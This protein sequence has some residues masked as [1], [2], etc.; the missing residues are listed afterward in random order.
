M[1]SNQ[2]IC[3]SLFG[4][5][6][7]TLLILPVDGQENIADLK[8]KATKF[9]A[10]GN[11]VE[12][13][14]CLNKLGKLYWDQ[15]QLDNAVANYE[16][17]V[18][19]NT[20]LGN[21]NAQRIIYGYLGM[22]CLEKEDYN[23]AITYFGKSFEMNKKAGKNSEQLS[24]LYNIA[25]A[26][27]MLGKYDESNKNAQTALNKAIELN[28]LESAKS[29]NLL[30]SENYDKMGNS[31]KSAEYFA[32]YNSMVKM[33]QQKQMNQ[34]ESDKQ[35]A[36]S[37]ASQ[38]Q[39]K[40]SQK[41][42]ELK[43]VMDTLGEVKELN[44]EMQL[45]KEIKDLELKEQQAR[46]QLEK[47]INE[48]RLKVLSII[49]GSIFIILVL[50]FIQSHHRKMV[51]KKLQEQNSE[52]EKQKIEI[53][54]QRDLAEKQRLNLTSSI[55]YARRIQSAVIPQP[56][57]LYDHF[58][59]SFI[60]YQPKDIVS[61]DFYWFLQKDNIF[62]IAVADCTGHG[63][64]GAF[65]SMLG[66]AYLNEIVN[67][68]AINIHIN[69]LNADEILNQLREKVITS[70]HQSNDATTRDGMDIALCIIDVESK[71]LQFAGANNPLIIVRKGE[72]MQLKAD[73]MPVSYHQRKDI[74]FTRQEIE[75]HNNDCLYLYSDGFQDQPGGIENR[76]YLSSK[77]IQFL[78]NNHQKQMSEQKRLLESEFET[79]RGNNHQI[80]DVLVVGFR[81]GKVTEALTADWSDKSILIAEDTDINYY[82]LA[83]VLRK[84][85]V[86]LI[87]VKD[88]VE[89]V[90]FVKMNTVNLILMDINM[91]NMNGYEA[92]KKIK[93]LNAKIPIIIQTAVEQHGYEESMKAGADD[94]ISKPIDLKV[95][96]EKISKFL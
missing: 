60:L 69:A 67:K 68:I 16:K 53:E 65:M 94:F 81:F 39:S 42:Q 15:N 45:Q 95:F 44:K 43:S 73:K 5:L 51:N 91:P 74:A 27:Q 38:A 70:L 1:K 59:D 96:M 56:E 46:F 79:W 52:I 17:S 34:L 10:E 6:I 48:S 84:N 71:K 89:A 41:E 40:V 32:N 49:I 9:E 18:S 35:M 87:R 29:C 12:L 22:I 50:F 31:K 14:N 54:K 78:Q 77:F 3:S 33:L 58:K 57:E 2:L 21:T 62:I 20:E 92:T 83:E 61:G 8:A 85:R 90:E 4:I 80:D 86:K 23:K 64:P 26:Y 36:E 72:I 7:F 25:S 11:K 82:L 55:Q 76:K 24:D 13:A 66:V 75:L 93:E 37:Q 30:L 47:K 63:V 28:N 19:I 88:G